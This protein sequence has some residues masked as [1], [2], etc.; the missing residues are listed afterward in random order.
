MKLEQLQTAFSERVFAAPAEN[1]ENVNAALVAD[2]RAGSLSAARRLE[3]YRHNVFSALRGGLSDLYPV[4]SAIVGE[5][6]FYAAADEF[7]RL[8]PSLSGDLNNFGGELAEFL[9]SYAPAATLPYLP[10]VAR[11]EW[12]W[13]RAYDAAD[14]DMLDLARL[15]AT[16]AELHS[17][18][19]FAVSPSASLMTSPY[20][21]FDIWRVNQTDYEGDMRVDWEITAETLVVYRPEFEVQMQRLD[22]GSFAFL[23][24]CAQGDAL[25]VAANRA[26][27]ADPEY[28][29]QARLIEFI[30]NRLLVGFH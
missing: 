11:M 2:I 23:T 13:H 6:F 19:T 21:L 17:T 15:A 7:I 20:P 30:Q 5:P 1:A 14:A 9:A 22:P 12:A 24:A 27:S 25:E 10:D 26:F 16:P 29:L 8:T 28:D 18:L 3:I 4:L